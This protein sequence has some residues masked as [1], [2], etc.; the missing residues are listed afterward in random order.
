MMPIIDVFQL[1][2]KLVPIAI[3]EPNVEL[4]LRA[5]DGKDIDMYHFYRRVFVFD[6]LRP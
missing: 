2:G 4:N 6:T 5:D 1:F 3:I